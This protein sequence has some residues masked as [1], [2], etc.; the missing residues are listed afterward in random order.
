MSIVPEVSPPETPETGSGIT[1]A[2]EASLGTLLQ[3]ENLWAEADGTPILKG[4][5]LEVNWGEI[6][7]L[8]GP[9]GSGK[10]T[11]AKVLLG[12]PDYTISSG[13]IFFKN[14]E[15]T[16]E[17]PDQRGRDGMFMAF[18]QPEA[19]AGVSVIQF[20]RQAVSA[21]RGEPVS[22][23][24]V[25]M[26]LMEWMDKLEMDPTFAQRPLNEGFSGGERKRHELLQLAMLTPDLA[27]LDE[28]D[29]GLDIDALNVVAKGITTIR[30]QRPDMGII[31][32]THHVHLLKAL[33]PSVVH[34]LIEGRIVEEGPLERGLEL[35]SKGYS[36]W[37]L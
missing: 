13:S 19:V 28:T 27:I 15:V 1:E 14:R 9:N 5:D 20:L 21:R 30:A 10:S 35:A 23:L 8:M 32:V 18:Q 7:A 11:L 31:L 16:K 2:S 24:E 6:H 3:V 4:I 17:P 26:D 12:D 36:Q 33:Q 29:T 34:V 22:A 25:R 37:R